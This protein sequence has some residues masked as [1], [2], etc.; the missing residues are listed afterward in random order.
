LLGIFNRYFIS[1]LL[2]NALVAVLA[3][4]SFYKF[5]FLGEFLYPWDLMLYNNVLNLLHN[6]YEAINMTQVILVFAS[7]VIAISAFSAFLI[8][9]KPKR[10]IRLN[11][12]V[13]LLFVGL[14]TAYLS[15]FIF[16]RSIPDA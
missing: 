6:L 13:R 15:I 5:S 2:T 4:F 14:G 11:R 9:K 7:I 12:W 3:V 1:F 8:I 16:Y 10:W